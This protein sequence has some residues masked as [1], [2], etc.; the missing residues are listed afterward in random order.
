MWQ[1]EVVCTAG[2]M[3]LHEGFG[4]CNN[5]CTGTCL[6]AFPVLPSHSNGATFL[7]SQHQRLFFPPSGG[8]PD[9]ANAFSTSST[10]ALAA[11]MTFTSDPLD[12]AMPNRAPP[13][14]TPL[15]WC[16]A[17]L[18]LTSAPQS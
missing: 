9:A 8:L 12:G 2:C 7:H 3:F 13:A 1:Q 5:V 11:F 17:T 14:A 16:R 10:I 4:G 15:R 18:L 6:D